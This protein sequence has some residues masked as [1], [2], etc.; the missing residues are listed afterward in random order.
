MKEAV[1]QRVRVSAT[2]PRSIVGID[3][4]MLLDRSFF[5]ARQKTAET[6]VLMLSLS[7]LIKYSSV[8]LLLVMPFGIF[9]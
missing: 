4:L 9:D 3:N 2:M 6:R 8:K 5:S 1:F 7:M